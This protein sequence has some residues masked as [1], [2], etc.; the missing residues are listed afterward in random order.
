MAGWVG[1]VFSSCS[2][3]TNTQT[4]KRDKNKAIIHPPIRSEQDWS[5]RDLLLI[6]I[7]S[8]FAAETERKIK[9]RI[10][11]G[12]ASFCSLKCSWRRKGG[13]GGMESHN[14]NFMIIITKKINILIIYIAVLI[15]M[16]TASIM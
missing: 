5:K 2:I 9:S 10:G 11:T 12:F 7:S 6:K 8:F 4:N 3:A 14:N 16:K 1:Q 15:T 13:V